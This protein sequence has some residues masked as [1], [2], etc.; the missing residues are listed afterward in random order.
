MVNIIKIDPT[1][2]DTQIALKLCEKFDVPVSRSTVQHVRNDKR[3]ADAGLKPY[4]FKVATRRDPV[5]YHLKT[6]YYY[7]RLSTS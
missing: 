5:H 1:V 2:T 7:V 6:S 4:A 3:M